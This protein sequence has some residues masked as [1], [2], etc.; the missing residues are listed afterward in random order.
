MA[1]QARA[2]AERAPREIIDGLLR[3]CAL[4]SLVAAPLSLAAFLSPTPGLFF[5]LVFATIL[6][7]FM[8]TSP[9]NAVVLKSVPEA[10]RASAMALCIFGIHLLGDLW[11]PPF[12]GLLADHLP[13]QLA[14]MALPV[15]IAVS[16]WLWWPAGATGRREI[17]G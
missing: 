2:P 7:L 1:S 10:L 6:A 3:I 14:M 15:A 5:A 11:S 17:H 8:C 16:A 9:I 12:V 13:V 4:G